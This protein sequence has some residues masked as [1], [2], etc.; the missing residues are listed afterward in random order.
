MFDL[1]PCV[2][3]EASLPGIEDSNVIDLCYSGSSMT[4]DQ[5]KYDV[6]ISYA[7][8]DDSIIERITN[9]LPQWYSTHFKDGFPSANIKICLDNT[10]T[11]VIAIINKVFE[12]NEI[13][14]ADMTHI[15]KR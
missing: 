3:L 7:Y 15:F 2:C 1:T 14:H 4:I 9:A 6:F 5:P 8:R 10:D 12:L 13:C 11:A